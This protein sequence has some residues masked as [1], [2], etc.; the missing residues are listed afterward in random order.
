MKL[1]EGGVEEGEAERGGEG[2]GW[3]PVSREEKIEGG[4]KRR[5]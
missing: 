2:M 1:A 3:E 4:K 5:R